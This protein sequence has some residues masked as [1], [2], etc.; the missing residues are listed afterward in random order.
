MAALT[1]IPAHRLLEANRTAT[2]LLLG[3]ITVEGL[4][5][6]GWWPQPNHPLHRLGTPGAQ[7]LH[8][9]QPVPG[10][11]PTGLHA[12]GLHRARPGAAGERHPLV[13]IECKSPS[14]ARASRQAVD[15]LRRYSNQRK[16]G[17]EVDD[18]EGNEPLFHQ[19]VAG[20]HQL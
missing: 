5:A 9:G 1:R 8:R 19:P 15:Q 18:N 2:D 11:L 16:A 12:Q 6:L 4:P 7:H 14:S 13:V 17:G 3:G 10:G 20:G